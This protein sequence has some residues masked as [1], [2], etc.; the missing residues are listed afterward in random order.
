MYLWT[1]ILPQRKQREV[2]ESYKYRH[3]IG[4]TPSLI[5]KKLF[6]LREAVREINYLYWTAS[7]YIYVYTVDFVPQARAKIPTNI[8]MVG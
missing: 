5:C 4:V 6:F 2:L 3:T 7:V 1:D 8:H